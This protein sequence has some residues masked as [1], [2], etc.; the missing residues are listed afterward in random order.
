MKK[1]IKKNKKK[2]S[3]NPKKIMIAQKERKKRV[4]KVEQ[5]LEEH[6]ESAI[7]AVFAF[8]DFCLV[9]NHIPAIHIT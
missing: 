7:W 2:K 5:Y 9:P 1:N 6:I 8:A 4:A 3:K